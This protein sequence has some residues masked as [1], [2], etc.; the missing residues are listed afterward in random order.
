M[1]KREKWALRSGIEWS[2][3]DER[4]NGIDCISIESYLNITIMLC[5]QAKQINAVKVTKRGT[6]KGI[7]E[8]KYVFKCIE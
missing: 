8:E 3:T 1:G 7:T 4:T 2:S 5:G 6:S